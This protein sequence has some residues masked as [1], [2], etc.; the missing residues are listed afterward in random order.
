MYAVEMMSGGMTISNPYFSNVLDTISILLRVRYTS[1][2]FGDIFRKI[3]KLTEDLHGHLQSLQAYP[4]ESSPQVLL[5]TSSLTSIL[6][7]TRST[8]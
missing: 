5:P 3:G 1:F 7:S 2:I 4:E 6:I 8:A